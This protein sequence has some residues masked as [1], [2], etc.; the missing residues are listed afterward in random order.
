MEKT[1]KIPQ[2]SLP[3]VVSEYL[4]DLI[5]K[6][7]GTN[8]PIGRQFIMQKS[9]HAWSSDA[10]DNDPLDEDEHEVAPG[11]V[12]K[13]RG[14]IAKNGTVTTYGR[15]LFTVTRFCS[16]YCRFCTR[17]REV[18]LPA[19]K[20]KK[21]GSALFQKPFLSPDDLKKTF[22]YLA[23]HKEINEVIVSGGDSLVSPKEYLTT[24]VNELVAL[25]K[26]GHIQIIRIGTRLPISNPRLLQQWHYDLIATIKNPYLMVHINHPKE[27]T[28]ESL[29]VIQK[30][31]K[32]CGATVMSQSVL[33]KGVNDNAQTFIDLFNKLAVNGIRPYYVF[34]CDPLPW[35]KKFIVPPH[36]AIELWK[37]IRPRLSGVAATARLVIDVPHGYGKIPLPEGD[38][39]NVD[40][41]KY[42]DFKKKQFKF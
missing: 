35:A 14:K 30:F 11:L 5:K 37:Q 39:W 26:K 15:A 25:Q 28:D 3:E 22:A 13:Y 42:R 41:T 21:T 8:G 1:S 17:G 29:A 40:F 10:Y 12:Y 20:N 9:Q 34:Q 16:S 2:E 31:R 32:E 33:L 19:T 24:V 6:T 7:G 23:K 4:R 27:L 36:K 18:G 38:A